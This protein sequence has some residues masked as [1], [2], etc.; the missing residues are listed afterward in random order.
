MAAGE[1]ETD[2]NLGISAF[3]GLCLTVVFYVFLIL[4]LYGTYIGNLFLMRGWVQYASTFLGAW[5]TVILDDSFANISNASGTT[6]RS[7]SRTRS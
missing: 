5:C 6:R 3:L 4:P 1:S 7:T 2:V